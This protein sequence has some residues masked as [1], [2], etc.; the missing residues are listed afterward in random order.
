MN[1][2]KI[3]FSPF[4]KINFVIDPHE[5]EEYRS[6]EINSGYEL[7]ESLKLYYEGKYEE[8]FG[9]VAFDVVL[10]GIDYILKNNELDFKLKI[11]TDDNAQGE[12]VLNTESLKDENAKKIKMIR[13]IVDYDLESEDYLLKEWYKTK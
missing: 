4:A 1:E 2:D 8:L 13:D 3:K 9:F 11:G 12:L 6:V 5:D 10:L 7:F